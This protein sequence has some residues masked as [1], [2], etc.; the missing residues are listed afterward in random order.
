MLAG[1]V[2]RP[3]LYEYR[4]GMTIWDLIRRTD[5]L[6]EN[7]FRPVAHIIRPVQ[8]TGA[9][10]L[11]RVSLL[12][13]PQGRHAEDVALEDRDSVVVFGTDSLVVAEY[14]TVE[15]YV[16]Q[17]G[18]YR[19][20]A[21]M[22]AEDLIL[23]AGGFL[24]AAN[25]S[26]AEVA[27]LNPSV[28]RGD[29]MAL[30]VSVALRGAVPDPTS[31]TA[32]GSAGTASLP[33]ASAFVLR[34]EDRVFVRRLAG[35]VLPQTVVA[36]GEVLFP[37][38]Y[39]IQRRDERLSSLLSRAGGVTD[40]AYV[41]GARLLRDSVLVGIDLV[42][43]LRNPAGQDDVILEPGDELVVP[44]YDGTV[45]VQGAVAFESR[46]IYRRGRD[47]GDYLSEAG[48]TL[49]EADLGRVSVLYASG[50]RA[51]VGR[52]LW[53]RTSP[54]IEPGS[55]IFVPARVEGVGTDWTAIITTSVSVVSAL[56]TLLIAVNTIG[57]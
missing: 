54:D 33:L 57:P 40:E 2:F 52:T 53:W 31:L 17:P 51:T 39:A 45:L 1:S 43:A 10:R 12:T 9:A 30:R 55:T 26:E 18:R 34:H 25:T 28:A 5:G 56:A 24:E 36:S 11:L 7:A 15:G 48:G 46:V 21:G 27:R 42:A 3:G 4:P 29:T 19:F 41:T 8:E 20:A 22:T 23:A 50:Q 49:S 37:G 6:A 44:A 13:D 32:S 47:L 14:V 38:P 16:K 35:F